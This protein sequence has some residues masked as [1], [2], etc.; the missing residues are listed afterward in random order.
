MTAMHSG[1]GKTTTG[2]PY[3]AVAADFLRRRFG[4]APVNH[5]VLIWTLKI[6]VK[7]DIENEIKRSHWLSVS[8]LDKAEDDLARLCTPEVGERLRRGRPESREAQDVPAAQ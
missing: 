5:Y 6:E 4:A 8:Q 3:A 1:N 7:D 2:N